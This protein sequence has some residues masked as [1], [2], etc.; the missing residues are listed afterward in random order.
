MSYGLLLLLIFIILC[1]SFIIFKSDILSPTIIFSLTFL[2]ATL[3]AFV[4]LNDWNTTS[5]LNDKTIFIIIL[6]LF[7][8]FIVE[9]F[10]RF[11]Y[12]KKT[13][14][15]EIKK[16][17]ISNIKFLIIFL[18]VVI[19]SLLYLKEL[20]EIAPKLGYHGSNIGDILYIYRQSTS[21]FT[22]KYL[23]SN[24]KISF[25]VSQIRKSQDIICMIFSYILINNIIYFKK[26][27]KYDFNNLFKVS[28]IIL[29]CFVFS[30]LT[31][32]RM[33]LMSYI[34]GIIFIIF[35]LRKKNNLF[36]INY[37]I[38]GKIMKTII[39]LLVV[40]YLSASL[41]G[42]KTETNFTSYITFYFGTSITG[43]D[44]YISSLDNNFELTR[45]SE[46]L[47]GINNI[48]YKMNITDKTTSL[49]YYW[50][51]YNVD[52]NY[53]FSN[54]F[55]SF[56][57]YYSDFGFF[58]VFLFQ[59]IYILIMFTLYKKCLKTNNPMIIIFYSLY[60]YTLFDHVRDDIFFRNFV[61]VNMIINIIYLII[62]YVFI[63]K[64]KSKNKKGEIDI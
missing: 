25:L 5:N 35:C 17:N 24:I 62:F 45:G 57:R 14:S 52:G 41:I 50:I 21:L 30:F 1:M 12:G 23:D 64:I 20:I 6:G 8:S 60:F 61:S 9:L 4:G 16:I 27:K 33:K 53:M 51:K 59:S 42:R 19:S 22:T 2:L 3:C 44:T 7:I 38:L 37:K 13:S 28:L 39:V 26:I 32:G 55:T 15:I 36:K 10:L 58:G 18:I 49:S 46:T 31:G 29:L 47:S 54:I 48:L 40:F 63:F 43:L 34:I 56:R 11:I